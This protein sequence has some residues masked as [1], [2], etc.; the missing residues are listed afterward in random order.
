MHH[1][2]SKS[3]PFVQRLA[4]VEF[5]PR[6]YFELAWGSCSFAFSRFRVEDR[7]NVG[8]GLF[9]GEPVVEDMFVD[10]FGSLFFKAMWAA[11]DDF[12]F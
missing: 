6:F 10:V 11:I 7:A 3:Q 12:L 5:V 2:W 1:D 4:T 9:S 8:I